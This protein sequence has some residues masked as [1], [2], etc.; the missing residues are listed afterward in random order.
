VTH[1]TVGVENPLHVAQRNEGNPLLAVV[2]DSVHARIAV[3]DAD[4][5]FVR[6]NQAYAR[7]LGKRPEDL[8]GRRYSS[9]FPAAD[10]LALFDRARLSGKPIDFRR[11]TTGHSGRVTPVVGSNGRLQGFV[12]S[13]AEVP[14]DHQRLEALRTVDHAIL[15]AGSEAEIVRAILPHVAR[16][17]PCQRAGVLVF[18]ENKPGCECRV[19]GIQ[20]TDGSVQYQ[21]TCL[22]LHPVWDLERLRQGRLQVISNLD[23]VTPR[24]PFL[25]EMVV[26]GV[27]SVVHVPLVAAGELMGVLSLACD[28]VRDLDGA[29]IEIAR[30]L[31]DRL[32]LGLRQARLQAEV[33]QRAAELEQSVA[34]RTAALKASEARFRTIFEDSAIGIA[35]VDERNR[36]V[37]SNPAL[38]K[39]LGYTAEELRG[40]SFADL[41]HPDDLP[42]SKDL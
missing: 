21:G 39:M 6:A 24:S 28:S 13:V 27:G 7:A 3:L 9:F 14:T 17:L 35:L 38:Q 29:G 33:Q 42:A 37:A 15:K 20:G 34:R 12:V 11:T 31:A 8:M 5:Y 26:S 22:S 40:R 16:L 19:L 30:D 41:I 4:L 18:D 2:M 32:A 23:D 36:V 10:E 1:G 25:E